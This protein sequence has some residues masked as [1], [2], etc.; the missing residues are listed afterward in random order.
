MGFNAAAGLM[1]LS[2]RTS[3]RMPVG[4]AAADV[5]RLRAA[6]SEGIL[7]TATMHKV[8]G[9]DALVALHRLY[10]PAGAADAADG[11]SAPPPPARQGHDGAAAP[12]EGGRR[13]GGR[14]PP[15]ALGAAVV[16]VDGV[17]VDGGAR[18]VW[19][20]KKR[21]HLDASSQAP[22]AVDAVMAANGVWAEGE[23]A[24]T[25]LNRAARVA[26][27]RAAAAA[28]AAT[29]PEAVAIWQARALGGG[30]TAANDCGESKMELE[31][32]RRGR[33]R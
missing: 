19:L 15:K 12:I 21:A 25:A 31:R 29:A 3:R 26:A 11:V 13:G 22:P 14:R 5:E 20:G 23:A 7:V 24:A 8:Q 33:A 30:P 1:D 32:Q 6:L 28:A 2:L 9:F 4:G 16:K 10:D 27:A 17:K 18:K